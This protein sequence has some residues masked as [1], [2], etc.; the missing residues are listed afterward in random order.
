MGGGAAVI[1]CFAGNP[2]AANPRV[3]AFGIGFS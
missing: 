1:A 2:N 3:S